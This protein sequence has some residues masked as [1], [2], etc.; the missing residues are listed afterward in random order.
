MTAL[1][2]LLQAAWSHAAC[3]IITPQLSVLFGKTHTDPGVLRAIR[4][5][6]LQLALKQARKNH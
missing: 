4:V 6:D 3:T 2:G 5:L 1:F